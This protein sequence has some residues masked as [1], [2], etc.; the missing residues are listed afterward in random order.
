MTLRPFQCWLIR[1]QHRAIEV[2][3]RPTHQPNLLHV[4]YWTLPSQPPLPR[5]PRAL[6]HTP[7]TPGNMLHLDPSTY[8][9]GAS[10]DIAVSE[11]TLMAWIR[12]DPCRSILSGDLPCP[13]G[14]GVRRQILFLL[15]CAPPFSLP[16]LSPPA[17]NPSLPHSLR[18]L[19]QLFHSLST[20]LVFTDG[21][22]SKTSP[23]IAGLYS[24]LPSCQAYSSI[25]FQPPDDRLLG[26]RTVSIRITD[27]HIIRGCNPYIMESLALALACKIRQAVR[28]SHPSALLP[29]HT[30]C[31][32]ACHH[33][34]HP[35]AHPWT[36]TAYF[37]YSLIWHLRPQ[38]TDLLWTAGHPERRTKDFS[39]W[40]SLEC[41]NNLADLFAS[42]H[43][44]RQGHHSFSLTAMEVLQ[45]LTLDSSWYL[46]DGPIPLL[47]SPLKAVQFAQHRAYLHN[48]DTARQLQ[49]RPAVWQTLSLPR[50]GSWHKATQAPY[51]LRARLAKLSYE[52]YIH[53][54]KRT[55]SSTDR[56]PSAAPCP[57]CG[58]DDTRFH[59]LCGCEHPA[60]SPLRSATLIQISAYTREGLRIP[61]PSGPLVLS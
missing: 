33:A 25:V 5:R 39:K 3:G 30:D 31:K 16:P 18:R 52:W 50:T 59:M 8:S 55:L 56:Y 13:R 47:I 37:L 22:F 9:R 57:L 34:L 26:P 27:G 40:S 1:S 35:P 17:P 19:P 15:P 12:E 2:L 48:R 53:G 51:P 61:C 4:R 11:D 14:K 42:P 60:V 49:G 10:T 58:D 21:S 44:P 23:G 41:G 24:V 29:I 38:A 7:L 46:A 32:S 43:P 28:R 36:S 20:M 6:S 54:G 45:F